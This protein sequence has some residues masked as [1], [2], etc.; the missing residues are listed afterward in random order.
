VFRNDKQALNGMLKTSMAFVHVKSDDLCKL[1]DLKASK[2][3]LIFANMIEKM[4]LTCQN[5]LFGPTIQPTLHST[6]PH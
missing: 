2:K 3:Q 5:P 1:Y 4:D 6:Q